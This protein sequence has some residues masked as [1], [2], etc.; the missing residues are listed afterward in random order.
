MTTRPNSTLRRKLIKMLFLTCSLVLVLA[1]GAQTT[2]EVLTQRRAVEEKLA[3]L[4]NIISVNGSAAL[5][6]ND[7]ASA[8][9]LLAPL[10]VEPNIVGAAIFDR[11]GKLFTS[12][13]AAP[14]SLQ[15]ISTGTSR[16]EQGLP[17]GGSIII[18]W[19]A[20]ELL[21]PVVFDGDPIGY[22]YLKDN[23]GSFYDKLPG[24]LATTLA[25]V[26]GALLIGYLL[27][28]RL[29][30]KVSAPILALAETMHRVREESDYRLNAT[31]SS[32]DEIGL[33][34]DGFNAMLAEIRH[35]EHQL[36]QH[37]DQLEARVLERTAQLSQ[38][39]LQLEQT[40]LDLRQAKIDAEAASKAKSQFLANMSHEIRTP[41]V[42][43]LGMNELILTSGLNSSQKSMAETISASGEALLNILEE[44]LDFSRIEAGKIELRQEKFQLRQTIED[45]VSLLAERAHQKGLEIACPVDP[46]I[47]EELVGDAGR[48][49]QIILNLAGNAIKFSQQ[50]EIIIQSSLGRRDEAQAEVVIAVRD[51]GIGMNPQVLKEVFKPFSQA[52]TSDTRK[53]G[54]TGLGLAIVSELVDAMQGNIHVDSTPGAGSTFTLRLNFA[55]PQTGPGKSSLCPEDFSGC[56]ALLVEDHPASLLALQQQMKVL[57]ITSDVAVNATEAGRKLEQALAEKRPFDLAMIDCSLPDMDGASLVASIKQNS[58]FAQ[59]RLILLNNSPDGTNGADSHGALLNKPVRFAHLVGILTAL[60]PCRPSVS[61]PHT[62]ATQTRRKTPARV[63]LAE[64]NRQTQ[65]L[66]RMMLEG[67]G[68][69]VDLT[70]DGSS[71]LAMAAS[72]SYD[73]ILMDCQMPDLD[74]IQTTQALR[75]AGN[76]TPIVALT[77]QAMKGDQERCLDAGMN[78]YLSK[79]FK[80]KQ[81][82]DILHRWL[83][84]S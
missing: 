49:R 9:E 65:D 57:G 41:L 10:R 74:G 58:A 48:L 27:L 73:L 46:Q 53:Y 80:Q 56:R 55:L 29:Q 15:A 51:T 76:Q 79:P 38:A 22:I 4:A 23:L 84:E 69:Q 43:I 66:V 18:D 67:F 45:A 35:R 33:L 54:G 11:S 21:Q 61:P 47:P 13:A 20:M 52:D 68:C 5:L 77:A 70:G 1:A 17:S 28:N 59:T 34:V 6:F 24:L 71:C 39:N 50:G 25:G 42:G 64:D 72:N 12:Y 40:I 44:L 30:H 7:P 78:D 2:R 26:L 3:M 37:R 75:A 31:V 82:L 8:R 60:L 16:W 81:L 36:Q 19:S 63:L 62:Q 32:D 14:A 83:P